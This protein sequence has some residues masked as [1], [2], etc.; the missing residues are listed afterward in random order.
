MKLTA[1][2]KVI[3]FGETQ[4]ILSK[5]TEDKIKSLNVIGICPMGLLG[6][7]IGTLGIQ[8]IGLM[9]LDSYAAEAVVVV[10]N[11][12]FSGQETAFFQTHN[13]TYVLETDLEV[14]METQIQNESVEAVE[15]AQETLDSTNVESEE[16]ESVEEEVAYAEVVEQE[17]SATETPIVQ[18]LTQ[19]QLEELKTLVNECYQNA[20]QM[21]K[22]AKAKDD[23]IYAI[24][25][26]LQKYKDDYYYKMLSPIISDCITFREDCKKS[27]ENLHEFNL[28]QSK[29]VSSLSCSIQQ[30]EEF[31][32]VQGVQVKDYL[33]YY[34]QKVFYPT[35]YNVLPLGQMEQTVEM[36]KEAFDSEQEVCEN[37]ENLEGL[38][39]LKTLISSTG[40]KL[41][42][43]ISETTA[44]VNTILEQAEDIKK[45]GKI[46]D[47]M[48]Q[49]PL[50]IKMIQLMEYLQQAKGRL[51]VLTDEEEC[52]TLYENVYQYCIDYIENVLNNLGVTVRSNIDDVYDPK[53]HR[54]L[55]MIKIAPEESDKDK[56]IAKFSTDCYLYGDKVIQ[57]AKVLVYKL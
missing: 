52:Q 6:E 42:A 13:I 20:A 56:K 19:E 43:A 49:T 27:L 32:D 22:L 57:P 1:E 51:E 33:Y 29:Q 9:E 40:K 45:Q 36:G 8:Q 53:C 14:E 18:G 34:N 47:G 54:I 28:N 5:L 39:G 30:I 31:L 17:E 50:F 37:V 16:A 23:S 24:N 44:L 3:L 21:A 48:L 12:Q 25:K 7:E 10:V 41:E 46:C 11:S 38:E 55:K 4:N 26:E 2:T 15:E 35:G